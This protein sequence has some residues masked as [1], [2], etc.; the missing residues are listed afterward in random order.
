MENETKTPKDK[1]KI[2]I[3]MLGAILLIM[4]VM[5][6]IIIAPININ[7]NYTSSTT[8]L[9][10]DFI[11]VRINYTA[12]YLAPIILPDNIKSD[13][14]SK[15]HIYSNL[16][17]DGFIHTYQAYV[18]KETNIKDLQKKFDND[19][20]LKNIIIELD[21]PNV[22]D[23]I[24]NIKFIK[25]NNFVFDKFFE[26]M[27]KERQKANETMDSLKNIMITIIQKGD[28]KASQLLSKS[29]IQ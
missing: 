25:F 21:I 12:K 14:E 26:D 28:L 29:Q 10:N 7:R 27:Y 6:A 4:V 18:I 8:A 9:T 20:T 23:K 2:I 17:I 1:S 11:K 13:I 24:N 19:D 3:G 16:K 5:L 22:S 15:I